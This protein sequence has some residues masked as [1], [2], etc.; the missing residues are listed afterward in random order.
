MNPTPTRST[1]KWLSAAVIVLALLAGA[2]F[3]QNTVRAHEPVT[4]DFS[5]EQI[6]MF[7]KL[8]EIISQYGEIAG[9]ASL[10]GVAAVMSID[11]HT[12]GADAIDFLTGALTEANDHAVRRAI[13]SKLAELYSAAGQQEKALQHIRSLVTG[14]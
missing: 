8:L 10:S 11:D 5:M 14:Q 12:N 4:E 6:E 7:G 13:H 9:D 3:V 2:L 1:S